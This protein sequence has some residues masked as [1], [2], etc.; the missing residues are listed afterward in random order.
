RPEPL[1]ILGRANGPQKDPPAGRSGPP[2]GIGEFGGRKPCPAQCRREAAA[3]T[4]GRVDD[5][6]RQGRT[7]PTQPPDLL[8]RIPT[9]TLPDLAA[10]CQVGQGLQPPWRF[11]APFVMAPQRRPA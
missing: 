9:T 1:P 3:V 10:A 8:N 4:G 6:E 5:S 11:L 7:V 2:T